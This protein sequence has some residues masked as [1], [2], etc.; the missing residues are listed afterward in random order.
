MNRRAGAAKFSEQLPLQTDVLL[1]VKPRSD[2][3]K[4]DNGDGSILLF[5]RHLGVSAV[6]HWYDRL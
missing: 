2:A 4:I 6:E 1:H 5:L 3:E